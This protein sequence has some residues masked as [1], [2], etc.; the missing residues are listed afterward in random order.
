MAKFTTVQVTKL[1]LYLKVSKN[2]FTNP[3]SY[4][5]LIYSTNERIFNN[6]LHV[7]YI[8]LTKLR[9]I[10]KRQTHH[11]LREEVS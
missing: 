10:H 2:C 8:N 5:R 4:R 11:L 1:L 9:H 3:G 6:T 7:R